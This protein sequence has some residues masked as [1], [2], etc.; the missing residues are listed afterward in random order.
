MKKLS[1]LLIIA[2]IISLTGCGQKDVRDD[3]NLV[4]FTFSNDSQDVDY[5]KRVSPPY[6]M[7]I[8]L[9]DGHE[10]SSSDLQFMVDEL[11]FQSAHYIDSENSDLTDSQISDVVIEFSKYTDARIARRLYVYRLSEYEPK[12]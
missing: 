12:E 9:S 7:E 2:I 8:K 4:V 1:I 11:E 3:M 10:F 6:V 5:E